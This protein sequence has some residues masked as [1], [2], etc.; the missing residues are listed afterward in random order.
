MINKEFFENASVLDVDNAKGLLEAASELRKKSNAPYILNIHNKENE[1]LHFV[2][3]FDNFYLRFED[4]FIEDDLYAKQL[5][6]EGKEL[7]TWKTAT[8]KVTGSHNIFENLHVRNTSFDPIHKGQEVALAVYGDDNLFIKGEMD[9]T[10]DTLFTGPLPDDLSTRYMDFLPEAERYHEGN[11][12]NYYVDMMIKGTVD[13]IF[14]AGQAIFYQDKLVSLKD[15]RKESYVAAPAHSLKDDFGF[16]F[17]SC[18]FE[19]E[20]AEAGSVYL[21]RPWRDYGKAVYAFCTY[22]DHIAK[23]GFHDWS[24]VNRTRTARFEEYPLRPARVSWARNKFFDNLPVRYINA[25]NELREVIS[26]FDK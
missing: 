24:D 9:S 21:G 20:G 1:K 14:G 4:G 15:G 10:Q 16:L 6:E 25:V 18:S 2:F 3:P 12:R 8:I 26:A 22:Q 19:K 5:D 7:T 17:H 11:E 23:A 13:F